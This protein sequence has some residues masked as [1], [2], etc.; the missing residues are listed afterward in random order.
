VSALTSQ[1]ENLSVIFSG[2]LEYRFYTGYTESSKK[3]PIEMLSKSDIPRFPPVHI[4][5]LSNDRRGFILY[6]LEPTSDIW[7]LHKDYILIQ[8]KTPS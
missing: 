7:L 1:H 4:Y 2:L 5:L 6:V 8:I 3:F